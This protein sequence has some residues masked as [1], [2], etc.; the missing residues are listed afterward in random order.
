MS[1]SVI[2]F[3]RDL[4]IRDN[5][6]L[7]A[8][9]DDGDHVVPLF[10]LDDDVLA[11]PHGRPNRLGFLLESL[12][13]LD[14]SL[15]GLGGALVMRHGRWVDEVLA[16]AAS[17][18]ALTVHLAADHSR[19]A[20]DRLGRL[21]SAAA[22]VGVEVRA[23]PGITVVDPGAVAPT[24]S[25]ARRPGV[26]A[27]RFDE[28]KVFTPY[29]RA[30]LAHRWREVVPTPTELVLPAGI[31]VGTVPALATL[32]EGD[33]A[34][35]VIP[36]GE[37]EATARLKAWSSTSLRSYDDDHDD[38]AADR[39][40]RISAHLHLGCLSPLEVATRLR[41]REGGGPFVRQLC[42]R[43]FYHQILAAR[44]DAA[45]ADYRP[46]G[47]RWNDDPDEVRAWKEGRTG[48]PIVDAGMRQ[49]LRE[50]FIH[51]RARMV[52]ASFL[53]KDLYADWRIGAAHFLDHLV[54]GDLANNQLNWQWIAGTGTDTNAH[55]VFNP[56]RQA[57]RFDPTGGYIRRYVPELDGLS[58]RDAH[59]PPPEVRAERGYPPPVVDHADAVAA[60]RSRRS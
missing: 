57:E 23:H 22:Q 9:V 32:T 16:V 3:T 35:D 49:L 11:T 18:D 20:I 4:R 53:V 48:Y 12:R 24:S 10:V 54:D 17:T 36:G 6:A 51:N 52:V 31:E 5:P 1:T 21:T 25:A 14:A 37:T 38:L 44:P 19:F 30:W 28:Y 26:P 40:S 27:S 8:A 55:R 47:D 46:R 58:P 33:R 43:D 50:G 56:L 59:D 41:S 15:R 2:V 60:Y 29:H 13:D 39:T 34:P 45:Y 7:A 42:W